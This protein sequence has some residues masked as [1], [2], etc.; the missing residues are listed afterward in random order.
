MNKKIIPAIVQLKQNNNLVIQ[1]INQYDAGVYF[2]LKIMDGLEEF[3]FS[4]YSIVV[5]S[6][7]KPDGTF[8]IDSNGGD[9]V[10]VIDPTKGRLKLQIPTSCLVQN[11]MHFCMIGFS[12]DDE[13]YV[14]TLTFNYYVGEVQEPDEESIVGTDEYPILTNLIA[15]VSGINSAEQER[16]FEED[17]RREHEG[18]REVISAQIL[19]LCV[20]MMGYLNGKIED[21]DS[22]YDELLQALASGGTVDFST[23]SALASK[24]YVAQ[25]TKYLD[26]GINPITSTKDSQLKIFR[27][28]DASMPYLE[29][30]ELGYAT[31]TH[32]LYVGNSNNV[33]G[34][35]PNTLINEPCFIVSGTAPTDTT[36]LWIDTSGT[37]SIIKYHDGSNWVSCNTAVFA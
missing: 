9:N 18:H 29:V 28:A 3:D 34:D 26:F 24:T 2:D 8:T 6:I 4:G 35:L 23:L 25:E 17:E 27:K 1:G 5:L 15:M 7:K 10:D 12:N 36:K 20:E 22:M 11:G 21:I 16:L 13:T 32:R 31:D 33:D 37:A 30:G 14:Q 19:A